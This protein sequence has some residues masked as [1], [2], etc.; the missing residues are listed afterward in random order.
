M[1]ENEVR[2]GNLVQVC[3]FNAS[4]ESSY[5][6]YDPVWYKEIGEFKPI[7]LTEEW[8]VKFGFS[9]ATDDS[10]ELNLDNM[11]S[12]I[13]IKDDM[14]FGIEEINGGGS[15]CFENDRLDYIH[16]LQNLY[17]ALTGEELTIK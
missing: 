11:W 4:L 7:P 10:F 3:L 12:K 16:R 2:S 6:E 1:K 14:S 5:R 13:V 15:V 8:L 9:K 17:F